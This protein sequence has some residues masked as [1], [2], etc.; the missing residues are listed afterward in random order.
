MEVGKTSEWSE[1]SE[2][3]TGKKREGGEKKKKKSKEAWRVQHPHIT[4]VMSFV[5]RR[6]DNLGRPLAPTSVSSA[7]RLPHTIVH[8]IPY[9][10]IP[11]AKEQ[12]FGACTPYRITSVLTPNSISIFVHRQWS[13]SV[14]RTASEQP[15]SRSRREY[16]CCFFLLSIRTHCDTDLAFED[17][18]GVSISWPARGYT[19]TRHMLLVFTLHQLLWTKIRIMGPTSCASSW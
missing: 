4:S 11:T 9:R 12:G 5:S 18:V 7:G 6:T 13:S 10:Y 3:Q 19:H 15:A 17:G 14:H 2:W 16:G 1:W 8:H